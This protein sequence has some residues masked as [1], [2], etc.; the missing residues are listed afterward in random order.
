MALLNMQFTNICPSLWLSFYCLEYVSTVN[1][2]DLLKSNLLIL[3]VA[4][5]TVF[6]K[7]LLNS[8]S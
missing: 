1:N 4:F 6:K 5:E 3:T 2:F 7:P 8:R